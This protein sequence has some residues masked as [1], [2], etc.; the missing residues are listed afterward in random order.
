MEPTAVR[1]RLEANP[2]W[3]HTMDI[4]GVVTDGWFDLRPVVADLPWPDVAG[5]RCLDIGTFDGF[6]AF[7]ME[8][9]GAAEVVCTDVPSHADWDHLPLERADAL[10]FWDANGGEKGAGF[11][12]AKELLGSSVQREWINIYDLSPERIGTFD[13]VVCGTLLLH[14]RSPYDA[15]E[16]VASVCSGQFLSCEQIDPVLTIASRGRAA[17]HLE[18]HD[19]RWMIANSAG[20]ARMLEVGGFEVLDRRRYAVPFGPG[21]PPRP[22]DVRAA[23]RAAINKVATGSWDGVPHSAV[24]CRP[25]SA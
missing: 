22:R 17:L 4:H 19:G 24:R 2:L 13:V 6:L 16:A 12:I 11:A 8:R 9:R 18:G 7:E 3:Y 10:A 15:I 25:A 1:A 5:K 14:L 21:H 23:G 20:H